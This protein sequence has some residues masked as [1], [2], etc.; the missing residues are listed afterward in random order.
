MALGAGALGVLE[1]RAL[2]KGYFLQ[3]GPSGAASS[4]ATTALNSRCRRQQSAVAEHGTPWYG[5]C[6]STKKEHL[7]AIQATEGHARYGS[8]LGSAQGP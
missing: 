2:W 8:A 1:G 4:P 5:R 7:A 3:S 6:G